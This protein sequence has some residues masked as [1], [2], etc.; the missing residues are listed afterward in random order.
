MQRTLY[1]KLLRVL[2]TLGVIAG[3][4]V[5]LSA[6]KTKDAKPCGKVQLHY[7]DNQVSGFVSGEDVLMIIRDKVTADPVGTPLQ[8]FDLEAIEVALEKHPWVYDAQLYFDNNQ[9]LHV[10]LVEPV[11]VARVFD[12]SGKSFYIDASANA[13]PLSDKYRADLPVF[14]GAP[15]QRD[16][17]IGAQIMKKVSGLATALAADSFWLA[18]AAQIDVL[19]GGKMEMY[20]AIGNHVVELGYGQA[21]EAM[22]ARLKVF[23]KAIAAAGR[24]Q[25]YDRLNA[26]Y[27]DQIVAK[28]SKANISE[29]DK[30]AAMNTYKAI[31][32][33]NRNVVN[34]GSVVS[35]EGVGRIVVETA[36]AAA[37]RE[38]PSQEKAVMPDPPKAPPEPEK[39]KVELPK[40]EPS[41]DKKE[42]KKPK[43]VMPKL[44]NK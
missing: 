15:V 28:R 7:K 31:V 17:A 29:A 3:G 9:T 34:A 21:P 36:P 37:K 13:L 19:P 25:T 6:V 23:Y 33:D 18:Q 30:T 12:I 43:A 24:L 16:S 40:P 2:L 41:A 35:E 10:H 22:L 5:L 14:T 38:K 1:I 44:E 8:R 26:T 4:M 11:P 42:E 20:P 39:V 32:S 27:S